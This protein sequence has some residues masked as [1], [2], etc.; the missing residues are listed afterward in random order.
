MCGEDTDE[1]KKAQQEWWFYY[2]KIMAL[3][4]FFLMYFDIAPPN[5]KADIMPER[6]YCGVLLSDEDFKKF[7]TKE[8]SGMKKLKPDGQEAYEEE[9][10]NQ[11]KNKSLDDEEEPSDDEK[12]EA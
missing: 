10:K 12:E 5:W 3:R 8:G 11:V 7:L 9:L 4:S 2:R 6:K 1:F